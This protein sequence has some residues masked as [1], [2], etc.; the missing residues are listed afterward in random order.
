MR[1]LHIHTL[2][3]VLLTALVVV[4]AS[5][6]VHDTSFGVGGHVAD[7]GSGGGVGAVVDPG[8]GNIVVATADGYLLRRLP[9][10]SPDATFGT[11]GRVAVVDGSS[12]FLSALVRE[13]ADGK[14]LVLGFERSFGVFGG[15]IRRYDADGNLDA[16]FG[17]GGEVVT[18]QPEVPL[19]VAIYPD[20]RIVIGGRSRNGAS[21]YPAAMARFLA[22]GTPDPTFGSGGIVGTGTGPGAT[23][24]VPYAL[25][26]VEGDQIVAG[27]G[28]GSSLYDDN[29]FVL[30]R[31]Q[32]D[33]SIDAGFGTGG[34]VTTLPTGASLRKVVAL[35]HQ[36]D[37]K[38][39]AIA[40]TTNEASI[41][42]AAR[43]LA[44]G[45][46]DPTY[47]STGTTQVE[48]LAADDALPDGD[49]IVVTAGSL[50]FRLTADGA[51][52]ASFAPCVVDFDP[53]VG[54]TSLFAGFS[55]FPES[56]IG[57]A[58][59]P[60]GK[61]LVAGE[62]SGL[63]IGRYAAGSPTCQPAG[64]RRSKL[65]A[66]DSG[67]PYQGSP[68]IKWTWKSSGVVAPTDFGN[69]T[70]TDNDAF[71]A[72]FLDGGPLSG[73][74]GMIYQTSDNP[75]QSVWRA[76]QRGYRLNLLT[77]GGDGISI[78]LRTGGAN[79]GKIVLRSG[80][81]KTRS[82]DIPPYTAPLTA[83]FDRSE[84][85]FCWDATFST[86]SHNDARQFTATSD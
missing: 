85:P 12:R 54:T 33:G 40:R 75:S 73:L 18:T 3:A 2:N 14:L 57:F 30:A 86:P 79:A 1:A 15:V 19:S 52:D 51:L 8:N 84:S 48:G 74:R 69:P 4:P 78:A 66:R 28:D 47:G 42:V 6:V 26:L 20:G 83:R 58:R 39:V 21:G 77:H 64:A 59:Q 65:Q 34:Y 41:F 36:V 37:G 16:S 63:S 44:D 70:A 23:S 68:K 61:L 71:V 82:L 17:S 22:N 56:R 62:D 80:G 55:D 49:G 10:G 50:L 60:D 7:A 24:L 76:G 38:V 31:Y 25:A 72:C 9:D 53:F 32:V 45:T 67:P 13:P 29:H 5:A 81:F 11:G 35:M 46:I 27:G 43:F